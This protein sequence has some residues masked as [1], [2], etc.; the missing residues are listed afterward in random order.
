MIEDRW[1]IFKISQ[2]F[3]HL[4]EI[5]EDSCMVK[6]KRKKIIIESDESDDD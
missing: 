5:T 6:N 3:T 4:T 2:D 1:I